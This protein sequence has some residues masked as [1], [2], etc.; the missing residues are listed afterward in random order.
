MTER[1]FKGKGGKTNIPPPF[2][3]T[4]QVEAQHAFHIVI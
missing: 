3:F 1:C 4:F 2:F